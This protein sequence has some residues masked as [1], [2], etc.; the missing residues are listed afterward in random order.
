MDPNA[1]LTEMRSIAE[2]LV[3]TVGL[4]R[5]TICENAERLAELVEALDGWILKGGVLPTDWLQAIIRQGTMTLRERQ[6][7]R[8]REPG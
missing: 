8:N 7:A 2:L 4:S 3:D 1:T 5:G 6:E